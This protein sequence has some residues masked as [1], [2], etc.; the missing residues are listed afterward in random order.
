MLEK[1]GHGGDLQTASALY[2]IQPH[3][4]I[5][6][7]ANINPL[8]PPEVI[9]KIVREQWIIIESYPDPVCRNLRQKLAQK[10]KIPEESILIGN[11]A[12]ELIELVIRWKKPKR[13]ALVRPSFSEYE[14]AVQKINGRIHDI[15]LD[16][17]TDFEVV[18]EPTF[19]A[20]EKA[21]ALFLGNPNNPT[22][23]LVCPTLLQNLSAMANA[24]KTLVL[25]EAFLSFVENEQEHSLLQE[26][27]QTEGVFV[28]RSM[29][30]FFAIPGLR[31]GFLVGHPDA[32]RS[33]KSL[34]TPWS[35]NS[36]A[37]IVG[38]A[39]LEET[40]YMQQT[41]LWLKQEL[42]WFRNQLTNLGL[43]VVPS[44]VNF[45]LFQLPSA[46]GMNIQTLQQQLGKR[47]ILIRDASRFTGL[48]HRFGRIA[49]KKR[50]DNEILI[51]KLREILFT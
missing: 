17:K 8:G 49:V 18:P 37:Q 20:M 24:R 5:D 51:K 1:Y 32:I 34:Q 2:G 15:W 26:A 50:K 35:V 25:D 27:S 45:L 38:E 30:K 6:F 10:W 14:Q 46:F 11:G 31:L 33:I 29:T 39:V 44:Q 41:R 43:H 21:D 3:E 7:S 23:K 28:I 16:A 42:P 13:T 22:G 19:E 48:D 47:G 12:A 40:A 9:G 36:F 4:F